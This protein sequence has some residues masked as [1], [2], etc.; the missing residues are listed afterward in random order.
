VL[1][2]PDSGFSIDIS[3][4]ARPGNW[5]ATPAAGTFQLV[6]TLFDTPTAGSSGVIDLAMPKLEKTGCGN[7]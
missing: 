3:A 6:L 4:R 1:R 2:Q 7:A 5:L